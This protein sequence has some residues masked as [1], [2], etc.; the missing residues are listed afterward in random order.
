MLFSRE[1]LKRLIVPL[2]LE[3]LL[4]ITV[5]MADTMMVSS[6]GEAAMSGVS[7]VDAIN[8]LLINLFSALAT[9]GAVL[10]SQYLGRKELKN[11][12]L[13]ARQ[14]LYT[15]L[16][17]SLLIMAACLLVRTQLLNA[18]FGHVEKAVMDSAQIYFLISVFSY[19]FLAVYNGAAALFRA[20]G[21]SKISLH[22]SVMMNLVNIVGNALFIFVFRWNVMGAALATLMARAAG[23]IVMLQTL[24]RSRQAIA[25]PSLRSFAWRWDMAKGILAVGIPTGLENSLF[26]LG[27]VLLNRLISTFG[28][29]S[30]AA[31]AV[32]VSFSSV[33]IIPG[34]A[35]G[36]AMVTVIGR[37]VG[38][39]AFDQA[40]AYTKRLMALTYATVGLLNLL[41]LLLTPFLLTFFSLSPASRQLAYTLIITHGIGSMITWPLAFTLPNA[42]RAA[43]DARYTMTISVF[44]M[45][46]FRVGGSFLLANTLGIGVWGVWLAQQVDWLFRLAAFTGRFSS[47]KWKTKTL[48]KEEA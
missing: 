16:A 12:G 39:K 5:G 11:A 9:G 8:L 43:N 1:D 31:N 44:S 38:A 28:T 37:C 2:M 40:Q 42:L 36:L 32:A 6:V 29:V 45:A 13:A 20:M 27:K 46:A 25:L 21:N 34:M 14:L 47:G 48:I 35:I 7:L 41:L 24:R 19:P 33:Q 17:A 10:T 3:Q 23:A 30:I 18:L 26:Q 22:T 15:V 4:A